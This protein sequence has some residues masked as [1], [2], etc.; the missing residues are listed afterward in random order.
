MQ[1]H[2]FR[3]DES[4]ISAGI[5]MRKQQ[6]AIV[7]LAVWLTIVSVFMLRAQGVDYNIFFALCLIGTLVIFQLMQSNY[8]QPGYLKNIRYFIAAEIVIFGI[9]VA[10]QVL[11]ILGWEIVIG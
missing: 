8:V 10:L 2:E 4:V 3:N 6:N 11:D 9:F 1:C 5:L 7:A